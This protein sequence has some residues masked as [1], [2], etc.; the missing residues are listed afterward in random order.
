MKLLDLLFNMYSL[1]SNN[2][3]KTTSQFPTINFYLTIFLVAGILAFQ[4]PWIGVLLDE[5]DCLLLIPTRFL[6][7]RNQFFHKKRLGERLFCFFI[8][9]LI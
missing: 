2:P 7:V 3:T 6:L 9:L 8:Y 1:D 5:S 4:P